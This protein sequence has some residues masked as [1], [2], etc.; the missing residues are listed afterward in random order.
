MPSAGLRL[1]RARTLEYIAAFVT[2][3]ER[4]HPTRLAIDGWSAAGKTTLTDDLAGVLLQHKRPVIRASVDD[5]H[6]PTAERYARGGLPPE[7]YYL[8]SF[9]YITF[10]TALLEPLG[11]GGGRRFRPRWFDRV[12]DVRFHNEP[13]QVAE[14]NAIAL[15]DGLF[16]FRPELHDVWDVRV[17][18]DAD[19]SSR[20]E[21]G[22]QRELRW[23]DLEAAA[24]R[25]R[26]R[27]L[28]G[29]AIYARQ[30]RP[31]EIAHLT[32]DNTEL[33]LPILFANKES[34]A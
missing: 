2:A 15:I 13:E 9:D 16:L 32:V 21:R 31:L 30:V 19:P 11:P 5:F 8:G 22:V 10:R 17:F 27:Y 14:D 1:P 3:V 24:E 29:G 6:R 12:N 20:L 23:S 25:Y 18:V 4:P 26:V 34:P 28:P 33:E 7:G